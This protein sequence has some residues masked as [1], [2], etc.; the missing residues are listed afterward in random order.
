MGIFPAVP[1]PNSKVSVQMV[2][3]R[4]APKGLSWMQPHSVQV[5]QGLQVVPL[6]IVNPLRGQCSAF[7]IDISIPYKFLVTVSKHKKKVLV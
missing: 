6:Y 4:V 3:E 1:A 2:K 7:T 5:S